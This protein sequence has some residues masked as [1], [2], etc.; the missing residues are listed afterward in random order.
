MSKPLRHR[1][2]VMAQS[3][4]GRPGTIGRKEDGRFNACNMLCPQSYS[5]HPREI[6]AALPAMR[7]LDIVG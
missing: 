4:S 2:V 3:G 7:G 6:M 5:A 1:H